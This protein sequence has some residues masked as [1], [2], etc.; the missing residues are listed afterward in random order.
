M[1]KRTYDKFDDQ[2]LL[3]DV[4]VWS[5]LIAGVFDNPTKIPDVDGAPGE[6][7]ALLRR[8]KLHFL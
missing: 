3:W 1:I 4:M 5:Q 6:E 8:C 2:D 7:D